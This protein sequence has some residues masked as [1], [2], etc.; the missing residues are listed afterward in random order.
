LM[1][2]SH[3]SPSFEQRLRRSHR[4]KIRFFSNYRNLPSKGGCVVA[5]SRWKGTNLS[6][7]RILTSVVQTTS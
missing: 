2:W 6:F 7:W 3:R 1:I 4:K 5:R